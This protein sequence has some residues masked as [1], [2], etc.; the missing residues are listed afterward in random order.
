MKRLRCIV[1]IIML[2]FLVGCAGMRTENV[3]VSSYEIA[4]TVLKSAQQHAAQACTAKI[5]D[6]QKCNQLKRTYRDARAAYLMAGDTLVIITDATDIVATQ[7]Q[8]SEYQEQVA[9]FTQ[10]SSDLIFWLTQW[11]VLKDKGGAK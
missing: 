2:T 7:H 11:G 10:L 6:E 4:G 5:L 3:A 1:S 9:R 8:L